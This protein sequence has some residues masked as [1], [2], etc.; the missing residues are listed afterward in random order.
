MQLLLA[1]LPVVHPG[2]A[3]AA[4]ATG[5]LP[6]IIHLLN[7]R[8][9]RRV[10]WAA[11]R[12]LFAAKK[13][14]ARRVWM[15]QWLLL[16]LRLVLIV[17]F[18]LA[19]AR[20]F[21]PSQAGLLT[22]ATRTHRVLILDNSLSMLANDGEGETRFEQALNFTL[23]WLDELPRSD[24]VSV[25]TTAYPATAVIDFAAFD[26]RLVR[27][28]LVS[29]ACTQRRADIAGAVDI[30]R[31][32]LDESPAL[33]VN[34]VVQVVSDFSQGTWSGGASTEAASSAGAS[35][36]SSE[37]DALD[38]TDDSIASPS[39]AAL[40]KLADGLSQPARNLLLTRVNHT[41]VKN[42]GITSIRCDQP[43]LGSRLP[44]RVDVEIGNFSDSTARDL[45]LQ[46]R[47]GP[48]V[49]R[50]LPMEAI[51]AGETAVVAASLFL[52][53]A[54]T[55]LIEARLVGTT[56][57][58]LS[59]DDVRYLSLEVRESLPLL[60][61]DGQSQS[62]ILQG[63]A[64]YLAAALSPQ[65]LRDS[66]M[67]DV[68]SGRPRFDG[69]RDGMDETSFMAPR[70]IGPLEL[71]DEVLRDYAV[72]GLCDVR[73][74]PPESWIALRQFVEQGGGLFISAGPRM[75]VDHFNEF[76]GRLGQALLSV[77]L[78]F[79][80]DAE[81]EIT[82]L[83]SESLD[84]GVAS[85]FAGYTSSGLFLAQ[86]EKYLSV[87]QPV[88]GSE[89]ALR[90]RNG[91][92]AMIER[93]IGRGRVLAFLSTINM[94]WGN[95][96]AK[97]DF[98][99]LMVSTFSYL[100]PQRGQDRNIEVG[101]PLREQL[102]PAE[103]SMSL[104]VREPGGQTVSARLK[105]GESGLELLFAETG[106][107]GGY[108]ALVGTD[109]TW[110]AVNGASSES[111]IRMVPRSRVMASLDGRGLFQDRPD[112]EAVSVG[113][114]GELSFAMMLLVLGLLPLEMWAGYYF[115]SRRAA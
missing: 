111:D 109:I 18:G 113:R 102:T 73:S 86:I 44:V 74:L 94:E 72:I 66:S 12:F 89:V 53:D 34:R 35:M 106:Q 29:L 84:H 48:E 115:G 54:G 64:G 88:P 69:N 50:R 30:A 32:V 82:G 104:S 70:V 107:S 79:P 90:F 14:D 92:P 63:A 37:Q 10:P 49:V 75:D 105:Q 114:A 43:I 20:P 41:D 59:V 11:M 93:S 67:G 58:A 33:D 52:P 56:D 21:L 39:F 31:H 19:I 47:R 99:S 57:D 27:E 23:D 81:Q 9:H 112:R 46:L 17:F 15:E 100:S 3:L 62:S 13:Q 22:Q 80:A 55:H 103:S 101:F 68:E 108:G 110:F 96:P 2:L 85:P 5:L 25:I 83:S 61:V 36:G 51:R 77:D 65:L 40:R 71:S 95:L 4:L 26:R 97:G 78:E 1:Q 45:V 6:I 91:D 8:R 87:R 28:A 38:I 98:V 16:L 7:R 42:V 60:L 76:A 24:A